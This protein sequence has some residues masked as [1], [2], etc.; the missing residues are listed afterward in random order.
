MS[1][2][3]KI[4]AR[5]VRSVCQLVAEGFALCKV[6][7]IRTCCKNTDFIKKAIKAKC[8]EATAYRRTSYRILF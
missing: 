8:L 5:S 7:M 2:D 1:K 3:K 4:C 6:F